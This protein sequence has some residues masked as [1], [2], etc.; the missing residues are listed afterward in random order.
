MSP[1]L[2]GGVISVAVKVCSHRMDSVTL[3]TENEY[4]TNSA[5]QKI[6]SQCHGW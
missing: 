6:K 4:A 3:T 5:H 1:T 2:N